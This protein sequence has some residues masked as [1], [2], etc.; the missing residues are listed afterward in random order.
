LFDGVG[1]F[2]LLPQKKLTA[3]TSGREAQQHH[4][5]RKILRSHKKKK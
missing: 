2:A 4:D 3:G 1:I 5:G